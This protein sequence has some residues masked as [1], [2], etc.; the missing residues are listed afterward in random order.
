M[1]DMNKIYIGELESFSD[2]HTRTYSLLERAIIESVGTC[3]IALKLI[4]F[5][6]HLVFN[7]F[8]EGSR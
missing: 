3:R 2:L 4:M 5:Q 1:M 8:F 6:H 7:G